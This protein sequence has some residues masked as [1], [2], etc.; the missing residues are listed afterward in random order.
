ML[1][2]AVPEAV[3]VVGLVAAA[4][5]PLAVVVAAVDHLLRSFSPFRPILQS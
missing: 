2:L 1:G 3:V 5:E 4:V